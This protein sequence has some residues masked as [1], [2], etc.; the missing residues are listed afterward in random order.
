MKERPQRT[1]VE[2]RKNAALPYMSVNEVALQLDSILTWRFDVV[3]L[4]IFTKKRYIAFN[5]TLFGLNEIRFHF[6]GM[7]S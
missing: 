1:T 5:L 3:A 4:E 6:N 7:W 2:R